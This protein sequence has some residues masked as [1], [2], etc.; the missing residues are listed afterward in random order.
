VPDSTSG[1]V[2]L[3]TQLGGLG[4]MLGR[5]MGAVTF[6]IFLKA[7]HRMHFQGKPTAKRGF[8]HRP[9]G[10]QQSGRVCRRTGLQSA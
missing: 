7:A 2:M 5:V 6:R 4:T 10:F 1:E 8:C 3:T 9:Y